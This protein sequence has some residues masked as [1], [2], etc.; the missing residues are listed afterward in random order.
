MLAA[1]AMQ[2]VVADGSAVVLKTDQLTVTM[3]IHL[4]RPLTV[5][6]RPI[7]NGS[8]V[9]A[10]VNFTARVAAPSSS[11]SVITTTKD[12]DAKS[13][14]SFAV[15]G[16]GAVHVNGVYLPTSRIKNGYAIFEKDAEHMLYLYGGQ[17]KLAKWEDK[18]KIYY[19]ASPVTGGV[20]PSKGSAW[21]AVAGADPPPSSV[22]CVSGPPL[23]PGPSPAPP[24]PTPTPIPTSVACIT[25][26]AVNGNS[27]EF[28][29]AFGEINTVYSDVTEHSLSWNTTLTKPSSLMAI[30]TG[31]VAIADTTAAGGCVGGSADEG[32]SECG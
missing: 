14:K 1:L 21:T 11:S 26:V 6:Y 18:S 32:V 12:C 25:I 19:V 23:P 31:T 3:D 24:T 9:T 28:C 22:T 20:P 4:P 13:A 29:K 17:W 7:S 27:T 8:A 10:E 30:L 5:L 16:S 15:L 2:L